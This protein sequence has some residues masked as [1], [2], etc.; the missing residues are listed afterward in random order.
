MKLTNQYRRLDCASI[1]IDATARQRQ[2]GRGPD[3][4]LELDPYFIA[5]IKRSGVIQPIIV[6]RESFR[7][8]AGERRLTA[9]LLLGLPDIPVRFVDELTP[10]EAQRLELE[11]NLHRTDLTW[12]EQAQAV[13]K[14]HALA[15]ADDPTWTQAQ[16]ADAIGLQAGHISE[17]LRVL[18]SFSDAKIAQAPT[19]RAAYNMLARV[20][21]RELGNVVSDIIEAGVSLVDGN[22]ATGVQRVDNPRGTWTDGPPASPQTSALPESPREVVIAPPPEDIQEENFLTWAPT[23][24]GPKFNFIHCDFPYGINVFGGELSGREKHT[25]Y[26]DS[27]DAYWA[28]IECLC[29][30][31]DR[32]LAYSGH[33]MFWLSADIGIQHNT[34]EFFRKNAPSLDFNGK[35]L[36]WH[37][38]DNVGILADPKRGPR[39]VYETAIFASRGDRNIAKAVSDIYSAPTDK[40]HHH[41]TKPEPMLR[42]FF[43]MFVDEHSIVLDPTCGSGAALRAAESLNAKSVLGLEID[44]DHC[45]SARSALRQFRALRRISK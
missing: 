27:P 11:E 31:L 2:A 35:P 10:G 19:L 14:F 6:E 38:S 20:D 25:T 17:T 34:L 5:S 4:K 30:N 44:P 8:H 13:A 24:S 32:L 9:S 12:Q 37:K 39:H 43:S 36:I 29:T 7:L 3:G 16:T 15:V 42:H 1:V 22:A 23:Y 18:R 33:L 40:T 21:Q 41:S 26:D 45:K 28:L